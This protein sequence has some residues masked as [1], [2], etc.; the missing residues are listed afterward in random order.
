VGKIVE[1]TICLIQTSRDTQ[2]RSREPTVS[3]KR[4]CSVFLPQSNYPARK[5]HMHFA[6]QSSYGRL[7][8]GKVEIPGCLLFNQHIP[9]DEEVHYPGTTFS[10][11]AEIR[12]ESIPDVR[13]VSG[14]STEAAASP[15]T[16]G[17][18]AENDA[19]TDR[20]LETAWV[21]PPSFDNVIHLSKNQ[22]LK[23]TANSNPTNT[24]EQ[25]LLQ[26]QCIIQWIWS[27][28]N[29]P[30]QESGKQTPRMHGSVLMVDDCVCGDGDFFSRDLLNA[31]IPPKQI[32]APN[33]LQEV[34]VSLNALDVQS[35]CCT[36]VEYIE[37]AILLLR[38]N[39]SIFFPDVFLGPIYGVLPACAMAFGH[40]IFQCTV[41]NPALIVFATTLRNCNAS[42]SV[43]GTQSFIP[44]SEGIVA[45]IQGMGKNHGYCVE[46]IVEG[47]PIGLK[48][49]YS[50]MLFC[51]FHVRRIS[52]LTGGECV[53]VDR[54]VH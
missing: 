29:L 39:V 30:G 16:A 2:D 33:I 28:R 32:H 8:S 11:F 47:L 5:R 18:D 14:T 23:R 51:V 43:D 46:H 54:I 48:L 3:K 7:D 15:I 10:S 26:R 24:P 27:V 19:H 36:L 4:I 31:N 41:D 1:D 6:P 38:D 42:V 37:G 50:T 25:K 34:V 49:S 44:V 17:M 35:R 40:R 22:L 52:T 21:K 13:S 9:P 45:S 20:Q 12:V 53:D